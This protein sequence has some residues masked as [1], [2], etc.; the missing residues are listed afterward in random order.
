MREIPNK[1][2]LKKGSKRKKLSG[3]THFVGTYKSGGG[4]AGN[5]DHRGHF[6]ECC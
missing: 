4:N 3:G 6:F 2:I 1:N 5:I